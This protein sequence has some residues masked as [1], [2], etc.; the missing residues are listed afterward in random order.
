[1]FKIRHSTFLFC[2]KIFPE[3]AGWLV[4]WLDGGSFQMFF[5]KVKN[6]AVFQVVK[7]DIDQQRKLAQFPTRSY[8]KHDGQE[9]LMIQ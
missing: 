4:G 1:M 7:Q 9:G 3:T 8:Q 2:R 5:I 6:L